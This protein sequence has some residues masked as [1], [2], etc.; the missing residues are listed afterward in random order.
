MAVA[1]PGDVASRSL[2]VRALDAGDEIGVGIMR[3]RPTGP[4]ENFGREPPLRQERPTLR[5]D[6]LETITDEPLEALD[7]GSPA[8]RPR[9][10]ERKRISCLGDALGRDV[11]RPHARASD[12]LARGET[13]RSRRGGAARERPQQVLRNR[14]IAESDAAR[15]TRKR[16]ERDSTNREVKER[17]RCLVEPLYVVED[18]DAWRSPRGPESSRVTASKSR[19]RL[20]CWVKRRRLRQER[21]E[22]GRVA[23]VRSGRRRPE[24][25]DPVHKG[26]RSPP[27]TLVPTERAAGRSARRASSRASGFFRCPIAHD[28]I[29]PVI[30]T[31]AVAK[32]GLSRNPPHGRRGRAS[33]RSG[34]V[35][36][37]ASGL[38]GGSF[39]RPV[40]R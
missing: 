28:P 1:P 22:I 15:C 17:R 2:V 33:M 16:P 36:V 5:A 27:R 8:E 12:S 9:D 39:R 38:P 21:Q 32:E 34:A 31:A 24:R 4:S 11:G 25:V 7:I 13:A 3:H 20:R 18:D 40:D 10:F 23:A 6:P 29:A 26:A 35:S 30:R 19:F 37:G 14:V